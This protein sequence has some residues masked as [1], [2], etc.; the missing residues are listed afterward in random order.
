MP[1]SEIC[2]NFMRETDFE[3]LQYFAGNFLISFTIRDYTILL[4]QRKFPVFWQHFQ[5]PYVF[6][7]RKLFRLYS[8][9]SGGPALMSQISLLDF[10]K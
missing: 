2:N 8:L 6:P 9:C 7:D 3:K 4:E 10:K 5:I 1:I